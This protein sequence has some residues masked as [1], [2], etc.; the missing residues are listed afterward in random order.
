VAL[1]LPRGRIER[2]HA[3]EAGEAALGVQSLGVVPGGNQ[4]SAS[5]VS[6]HADLL[7]E[8]RSGGTH[9]W[10]DDR[11]DLGD[12]GLKVLD[13]AGQVAQCRLGRPHDT[14]L[15]GGPVSD[16]PLDETEVGEATELG[17]EVLGGGGDD[18]VHLVERPGAVLPGRELHQA[19]NPDGLDVS[20]PGLGFALGFS[21]QR[22]PGGG[23]GVQG[24]GLAPQASVLAVGTVDLDD[25]DGF[26]EQ[27][28]GESG[29][30]RSG[31]LHP[32]LLDLS[33]APEPRQ[34]SPVAGGG[35]R[36]RLHSQ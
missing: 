21:R 33:E 13:P 23:H 34:Q 26:A 15:A 36:E 6:P 5:T 1:L 35:G 4:Q 19:K 3:T 29:A 11:V 9:Q 25:G 28:T 16:G 31:A 17:S 22:R 14:G 10:I 32:H 27:V 8:L 12:L 24:I 2:G 30:R 7:E 18:G 20:V